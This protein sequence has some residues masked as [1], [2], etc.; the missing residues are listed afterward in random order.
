MYGSAA[1]GIS[2][3]AYRLPRARLALSQLEHERR[4][5]TDATSLRKLGFRGCYELDGETSLEEL[6][7][8]AGQEA[9]G[10]ADLDHIAAL[11]LYSGIATSPASRRVLGRFRYRA[12]RIADRLGLGS[13]MSLALSE[14]GCGGSLTSIH[15]AASLLATSDRR[16]VLCLSGDSLPPGEPREVMHSLIS[17]AAAAVLVERDAAHDRIVGYHQVSAPAYWDTPRRMNELLAAYFPLAERAIR[18]GLTAAGLALGDVQ[19]FVP[20]NVSPRSWK[21]LAGILGVPVERAWLKNVPRAG[22]TISCDHVLNLVEMSR[23]GVLRPGD[24][25]LLFTFGFGASWTT[26]A[27][28]H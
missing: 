14:Q 21:I 7:V 4:L 1:A 27:L 22:H 11:L 8:E 26:L 10:G 28:R 23:R 20:S 9:L 24:H 16:S 17:D 12:P 19:W 5:V 6:L 15:L 13:A 18:E 25:V 3:L 2:R